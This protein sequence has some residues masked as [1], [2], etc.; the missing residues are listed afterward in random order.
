M[1]FII[2]TLAGGR[3]QELPL[4]I[5]APDTSTM[6]LVPSGPFLMGDPPRS[7][8][9][10]SRVAHVKSFYIDEVEVNNV[11]YSKFLEWVK[12][13]TDASVRH[14]DQPPQKD[15]TP[16]YWK[17]FRPALLHDTGMAAI[18]HFDEDTFRKDDHPVVGIDWYDAYAY[19]KW[20][21]KRLP[22]EEEWEKAAR[23]GD[24]RIWPWGNS[25]T[26]DKC[27]SGGYEWKGERDG[28]IYSAP[29]QSYPEGASPYGCLNMA[30][31]VAEWVD[32]SDD[33]VLRVIKG[34]G[35]DSYPS[36]VRAAAR[37][38]YEPTF[39]SFTVGF[40][41]ARDASRGEE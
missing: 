32:A 20:A 2:K 4:K 7:Q 6:V 33:S 38:V 36:S 19:A 30:G 10:P 21:L 8:E 24:G 27:N 22:T 13:N 25:F 15:H 14:P 18:Q 5:T 34:G 3:F 37:K 26:F 23:G 11:Q 29:V 35:S 41:C 28:S 1:T 16:R 12:V 31:N 39:R 9:K 17:P 40:R